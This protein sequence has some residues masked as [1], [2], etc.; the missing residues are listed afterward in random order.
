MKPTTA[1]DWA[2]M[3]HDQLMREVKLG[4]AMAARRIAE[5]LDAAG[6]SPQKGKG[7]PSADPLAA[8]LASFSDGVDQET[9][10][11][12]PVSAAAE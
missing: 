5:M 3:Q 1:I 2:S 9:E 6:L 4:R 10:D 7:R 8:L 12:E 11:E